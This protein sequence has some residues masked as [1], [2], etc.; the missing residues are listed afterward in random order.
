MRLGD[1]DALKAFLIKHKEDYL[2]D[3]QS[4]V[5]FCLKTIDDIPTEGR[6]FIEGYNVGFE[7]GKTERP[8]GE[9]IIDGHHIR[10]NKYNEYMCAQDREGCNIPNNYCPNCGVD[11]RGEDNG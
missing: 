7:M 10:C 8:K 3:F 5:D 2:G 11:M 4:G 6:T 1:L 9:W